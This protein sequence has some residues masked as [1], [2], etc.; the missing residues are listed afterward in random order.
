MIKPNPGNEMSESRELPIWKKVIFSL[1]A[2]VL[3]CGTLEVV[4]A[5]CGVQPKLLDEDPFVGSETEAAGAAG[6]AGTFLRS[7]PFPSVYLRCNHTWIPEL[8]REEKEYL[9]AVFLSR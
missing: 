1:A 6:K 3:F 2:I 9:S 5:L 7:R 8:L 4:L